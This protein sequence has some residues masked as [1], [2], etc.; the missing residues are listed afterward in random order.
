MVKGRYRR[1]IIN[2]SGVLDKIAANSNNLGLMDIDSE[3]INNIKQP[4]YDRAKALLDSILEAMKSGKKWFDALIKVMRGIPELNKLA[5]ELEEELAIEEDSYSKTRSVFV[6]NP[7]PSASSLPPKLES[8]TTG[9]ERD[10]GLSGDHSENFDNASPFESEFPDILDENELELI[11][12]KD[13]EPKEG[14]LPCIGKLSLEAVPESTMHITKPLV[15]RGSGPATSNHST[16]PNLGY[17]YTEQP[18]PFMGLEETASEEESCIYIAGNVPESALH[19]TKLQ[20]VKK[21]RK[22]PGAIVSQRDGAIANLSRKYGDKNVEFEE[23][24]KS[25]FETNRDEESNEETECQLEIRIFTCYPA[26]A[27]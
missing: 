25:K 1:L 20:A 18:L 12:A 7:P 4:K 23:I 10:S 14:D 16:P 22:Q 21:L 6:I 15:T 13:K 3:S 19:D 26:R 9:V 17:T 11:T 24:V 5:D 8:F 2:F 27:S